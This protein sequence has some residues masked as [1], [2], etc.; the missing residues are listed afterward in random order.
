MGTLNFDD[1]KYDIYK[2]DNMTEDEIDY[3]IKKGII[4]LLRLKPHLIEDIMLEVRKIKIDKIKKK[5]EVRT[6]SK[7]R[8]RT[9]IPP[10]NSSMSSQE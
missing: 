5:N 4:E 7:R 6:M 3:E 8:S 2:C 10:S 9:I 1:E